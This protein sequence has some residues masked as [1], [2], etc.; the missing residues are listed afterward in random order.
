MRHHLNLIDAYLSDNN[1]ARAQKYISEVGHAIDDTV[2]K[3][4]CGNYTVNLILSSYIAKANNEEIR[5]ETQIDL[6]EKNNIL[7][8]DL[9][10]IF[11]NA[12]ENATNACKRIS[13]KDR[14]LNIICKNKSNKL[15]IQITN[16]YEGSVNFIGDMPVRTIENHGLGIKSIAAV[17]Q[18]YGGLCSFTAE[19]GLFSASI[20]L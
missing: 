12:I 10:I 3:K 17:A 5:V 14:V 6:P 16:R 18:K 2:V 8:M 9:C 13:L 11:A 1:K 15:F 20:I 7:D 4:Y 19:D